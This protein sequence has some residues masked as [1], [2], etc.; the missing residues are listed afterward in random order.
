MENM[1][2]EIGPMNNAMGEEQKGGMRV[3][4]DW[5]KIKCG[6]AIFK[7]RNVNEERAASAREVNR[8]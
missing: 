3:G 5:E 2:R 1:L 6:P 4:G 8:I 7:V